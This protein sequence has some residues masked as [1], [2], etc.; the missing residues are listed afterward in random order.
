MVFAA[1]ATAALQLQN[2]YFPTEAIG[3]AEK[4][5]FSGWSTYMRGLRADSKR[6]GSSICF[7][8]LGLGL[9]LVSTEDL[10]VDHGQKR[11][12]STMVEIEAAAR[13]FRRLLISTVDSVFNRSCGRTNS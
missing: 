10:A 6:P 9:L 12:L 3:R 4:D 7:F 8:W 2:M 13:R 1:N 5:V 11:W